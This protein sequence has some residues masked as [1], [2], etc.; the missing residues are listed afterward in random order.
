MAKK[1]CFTM[2]VALGFLSSIPLPSAHADVTVAIDEFVEN[3]FPKATHY[4]WVV[5]DTKT[6]TL[7]EVIVDI[8]TIVTKQTGKEP[9]EN[10]FL[11]LLVDGALFAAQEIPLGAVVDCGDEQV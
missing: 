11:L 4:F 8:N 10:R 2:I 9:T 7:R 5:N 1:W 6:E 3:L